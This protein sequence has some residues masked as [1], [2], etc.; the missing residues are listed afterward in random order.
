MAK[1]VGFLLVLMGYV[2]YSIHSPKWKKPKTELSLVKT[3][4]ADLAIPQETEMELR[5]TVQLFKDVC[6]G[7]SK[8]YRKGVLL[9]GPSGTGKTRIT[10]AIANEANVNLVSINA[11]EFIEFSLGE[12]SKRVR[13][14]FEEARKQA[15]CVL[16]IDELDAL[17]RRGMASLSSGLTHERNLTINQ[18]LVE[19]DGFEE[20]DHVLIIAATN[21]VKMVESALIRSGRFDQKIKLELPGAYQRYQI[22]NIKI[23]IQRDASLTDESILD[24]AEKTAGYSG[25]DIEA[26]INEAVYASIH[27]GKQT[28][29]LHDLETAFDKLSAGLVADDIEDVQVK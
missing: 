23:R 13:E 18:L 19:I 27:S 2:S 17:G 11:S 12:G 1:L 21:R 29:A 15:P 5:Q 7:K 25:A 3:T 16:F 14:L 22:L 6:E 4:F 28:L 24:I 9:Y 10:R 26:L 20:S 8:H